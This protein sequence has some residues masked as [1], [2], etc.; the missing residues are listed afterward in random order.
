[1]G[2]SWRADGGGECEWWWLAMG[3]GSL[4]RWAILAWVMVVHSKLTMAA[5]HRL[6]LAT[7]DL[8]L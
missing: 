5:M 7:R 8:R 1:M 4:V 6:W 3:D 2:G